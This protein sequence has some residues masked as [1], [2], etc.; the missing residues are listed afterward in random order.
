MSKTRNLIEYHEITTCKYEDMPYFNQVKLNN[1][2][3]LSPYFIMICSPIKKILLNH[4]HSLVYAPLLQN[5]PI[6]MEFYKNTL[7]LL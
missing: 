6:S 1:N 3:Y 5:V 7:P 2:F 4:S